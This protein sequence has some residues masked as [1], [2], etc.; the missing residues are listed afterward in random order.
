MFQEKLTLYPLA[1]PR[2]FPFT[3]NWH[4]IQLKITVNTH[5]KINIH[6]IN[7]LTDSDQAHFR[8]VIELAD[9]IKDTPNQ[10]TPIRQLQTELTRKHQLQHIP[11]KKLATLTSKG[12]NPFDYYYVSLRSRLPKAFAD[13]VPALNIFVLFIASMLLIPGIASSTTG[14]LLAVS[15]SLLALTIQLSS[16]P[17][18]KKLGVA[19]NRYLQ[20]AFSSVILT[21]SS[22]SSIRILGS[23][24][25]NRALV[26]AHHAQDLEAN[27]IAGVAVIVLASLGALGTWFV[28][29]VSVMGPRIQATAVKIEMEFLGNTAT[30]D[31]KVRE[32]LLAEFKKNEG[33]SLANRFFC[34]PVKKIATEARYDERVIN[35]PSLLVAGK[36][37]GGA[38]IA[39]AQFS[40]AM[41]INPRVFETILIPLTALSLIHT[42]VNR[43][44]SL[45][46]RRKTIV[47]IP[48]LS[49]KA[50]YLAKGIKWASELAGVGYNSIINPAI[51]L[52]F[53]IQK[54]LSLAHIGEEPGSVGPING[55]LLA[56][57]IVFNIPSLILDLSSRRLGI[58]RFEGWSASRL[59]YIL[60]EA[61][62]SSA[63]HNLEQYLHLLIESAQH[64][65]TIT[66]SRPAPA[67]G[68]TFSSQAPRRSRL[69]DL[70]L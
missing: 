67:T 40:L 10:Q 22:F 7:E 20:D 30:H 55:T 54:L 31:V 18:D 65:I 37:L 16:R 6:N 39:S 51:A 11:Y 42:F 38:F 12:E 64:N 45:M 53:V 19:R 4:G 21:I 8:R 1:D 25:A 33:L 27:F 46:A 3:L 50:L 13:V 68:V 63:R 14:A 2:E 49:D 56:A 24:F 9:R 70:A 69:R 52:F 60:D 61:E 15:L 35:P 34:M 26:L 17:L 29:S 23:I 44:F 36:R 43:E 57:V 66:E 59:S 58:D 48:A 28:P 5:G 32:S 41:G 62:N 47:K